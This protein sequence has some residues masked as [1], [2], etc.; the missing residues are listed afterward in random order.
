MQTTERETAQSDRQGWRQEATALLR[1]DHK[2]VA[3]LFLE[4][5]RTK[6]K[7]YKRTLID[8]ICQ[9]LTVHA[10][11]EEEIFYPAVREAIDEPEIITEAGIEHETLKSLIGRLEQGQPGDEE[12]EATVK[13]LAEYVT[14]HVAEEQTEIFP[15][16]RA[17][18][19]DLR[20]LGARLIARKA[21]LMASDG[22]GVKTE[23]ESGSQGGQSATQILEEV[24]L[25]IK[26]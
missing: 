16:A 6:G 19:L 25:E 8:R 14:L 24:A 5:R 10:Q 22:Q 9:E 4:Y 12:F 1:A 17:S 23:M 26:R 21:E 7:D 2:Q 13:V 3:G 20:E 15:R 11:V 18:D